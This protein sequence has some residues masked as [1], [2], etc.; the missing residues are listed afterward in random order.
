[1]E[2]R[3]AANST[4]AVDE[5]VLAI[6]LNNSRAALWETN[7][8]AALESLTG[9]RPVMQPSGTNS[10]ARWSLTKHHAPNLI[11]LARVGDWTLVGAAQNHN[12]LLDEVL[13]RANQGDALLPTHSKESWLEISGNLSRLASAV[14][15]ATEISSN[16]PQVSF[17]MVGDPQYVLTRGE[18]TLSGNK[19][20]KL[21]AWDIPTNLIDGDLVSFTAIRGFKPWLASSK[22]WTD[23][24]IGPP[25]NQ[26]CVWAL[27]A[28]PIG[29]YV[30]APFSDASNAV[31]RFSDLVVKKA[32]PW[33]ATNSLA[34]FKKSQTFNG[35]SWDGLPYAAPFL[36]SIDSRRGSFVFGGSFPVGSS[37]QPF[38]PALLKEILSHTNL[39]YYDW[40]LTGPRVAQWIHLGQ[41]SRFVSGK[42]QLPFDSSSMASLKAVV[43]RLESSGTEINQTAPGQLSFTRN[44]TIGFTAIE[45]HLL[46]DWLESPEFPLG[47]HT[48]SASASEQ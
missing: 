6:R 16:L 24:Q 14:G 3:R 35:L 34:G 9:I 31:A 37:T 33:F 11:E 19:S 22:M 7:L 5:M 23:L 29:T 15:I 44:S 20:M 4:N 18:I 2:V 41:F 46:A 45:L 13:T 21:D 38:P 12:V 30:S 1:V 47:F 17:T 39:V 10:P 40:E 32:G 48:F 25:P 42:E 28:L 43:T 36:K 26:L 27:R 8:A